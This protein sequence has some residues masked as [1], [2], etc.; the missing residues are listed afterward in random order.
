M[1]HLTETNMNRKDERRVIQLIKWGHALED[2]Y[3]ITDYERSERIGH[4]KTWAA[5][6]VIFAVWVW[7]GYLS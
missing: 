7:I 6:T 2:A 4:Y 1:E 5:L 3:A